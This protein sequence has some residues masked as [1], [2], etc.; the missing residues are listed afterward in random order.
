MISWR[1]KDK[2]QLCGIRLQE[3]KEKNIDHIIPRSLISISEL[4]NLQL[5]CVTCNAAKGPHLL[6]NFKELCH[7]AIDRT[8]MAITEE[9][10]SNN[11]KKSLSFYLLKEIFENPKNTGMKQRLCEC[12]E[13]DDI[14]SI[15]HGNSYYDIIKIVKI[16]VLKSED[17]A[18]NIMQKCVSEGRNRRLSEIINRNP[19]IH[20]L[21]L[22]ILSYDK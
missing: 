21:E 18:K 13:D 11:T 3:G 20:R 16:Y 10:Q 1:D 5:L 19:N 4:W 14:N 15:N 7:A 17:Q 6:S 12:Y 9:D 8:R 22:F 2:C